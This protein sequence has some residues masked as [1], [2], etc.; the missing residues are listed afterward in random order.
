MD[1]FNFEQIKN[2][3]VP[4]SWVEGALN[5]RNEK[6]KKPFFLRYYQYTIGFAAALL[7][8]VGVS[9]FMFFGT[10]SNSRVAIPSQNP[11]STTQA[12]SP[13]GGSTVYGTDSTNP[14]AEN[15]DKITGAIVTEPSETDISG[16]PSKSNRQTSTS[17]SGS[18][19]PNSQ[20]AST[21]TGEDTPSET[22]QGQT[23]SNIPKPATEPPETQA[24]TQ[25]YPPPTEEPT[26]EPGEP[27]TEEPAIES[28]LT[29]TAYVDSGIVD[30]N[31]YCRIENMNGNIIGI[32][33]LYSE[34]RRAR[35]ISSGNKTQLYYSHTY[36]Y[37]E[38]QYESYYTVKFY[39]SNG[40]VIKQGTVYIYAPDSYYI[41]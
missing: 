17:P 32:G 7:I 19:K 37:F 8:A 5:L 34:S 30:G 40:E 23:D 41:N 24:P 29:F 21:H 26:D 27:A 22:Q 2:F 4:E 16:N 39:N 1:K 35:K 36:D 28:T 3:E 15:K 13:S 18:T 38:V 11:Q 33:G 12:L 9:L 10:G 6:K 14:S 20:S 31:I 25:Y